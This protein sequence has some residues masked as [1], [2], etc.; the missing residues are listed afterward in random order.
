MY[1]QLPLIGLLATLATAAPAPDY[2]LAPL[3]I[4]TAS[5]LTFHGKVEPLPTAA[6][7]PTQDDSGKFPWASSF[8][9][10]DCSG[11]GSGDLVTLSTIYGDLCHSFDSK[12]NDHVLF[13]YGS[14]ANHVESIQVYSDEKCQA[15]V[16][17]FG[18]GTDDH[19]TRAKCISIAQYGDNWH[20]GSF[21]LG[22]SS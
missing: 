15:F 21:K 20:Q 4:P 18:Y 7:P 2:T 8:A 3:P 19:D 10:A 16:N 13:N 5:A 17:S 14:G 11:T 9:S 6:P 12:G 22:R 1:S